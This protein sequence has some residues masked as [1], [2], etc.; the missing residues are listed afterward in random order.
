MLSKYHLRPASSVSAHNLSSVSNFLSQGTSF[1][2]SILEEKIS[3][4]ILNFN[5]LSFL[6]ISIILARVLSTLELSL[7]LYTSSAVQVSFSSTITPSMP[8]TSGLLET[9]NSAIA[10]CLLSLSKSELTGV[11]ANTHSFIASQEGSLAT[12]VLISK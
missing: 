11:L 10:F 1:L 3:L 9:E 4:K 2:T 6:K 7:A 12:G 5:S 8:S